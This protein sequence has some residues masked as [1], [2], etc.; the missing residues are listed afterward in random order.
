VK[1]SHELAY[2]RGVDCASCH[3]DIIR[4]NGEVPKER[5]S[6]CHNRPDDLARIGDHVFLHQKHVTDHKIDCLDCHLEIQHSLDPRKFEHA[7]SNCQACHANVHIEQVRLLR[8]EGAKSLPTPHGGMAAAGISCSSCHQEKDTSA[9]GAVVWKA[10]AAVCIQCH[11]K[12]AKD[13]VLDRQ[14]Q[15]QSLLSKIETELLRARETIP[16]AK[17]DEAQTTQISKRLR[18]LEDDLQFLR[19]GN[20]IH[21]MHY[22][23]SLLRA[24]LENLRAICL[25]LKIAEP[26]IE[27]PKK[28][29]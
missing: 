10:S 15:L 2:E 16:T 3:S 1:F 8:G 21:N 5:C 24:L 25:E 17:L 4:G 18:D 23:D 29:D 11:D 26:A 6:V 20:S 9:A 7:A 12:A 27:P 22:A 14:K 19:V 28:L 13:R